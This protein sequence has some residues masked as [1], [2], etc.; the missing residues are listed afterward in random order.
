ML[1]LPQRCAFMVLV[2]GMD[3]SA[4]RARARWDWNVPRGQ[5]L[6]PAV[7]TFPGM[8]RVPVAGQKERERE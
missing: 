5:D 2:G 7:G 8:R 6:P 3:P 4:E 1:R